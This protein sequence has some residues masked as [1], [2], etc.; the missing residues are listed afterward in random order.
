MPDKLSLKAELR[1]QIDQGREELIDLTRDLLRFDTENPP[2]NSRPITEYIARYL[3]DAGIPTGIHV[4]PGDHCNL[5]AEIEA[6][7]PGK[8]LLFCGHTDV[9]PAGD[10]ARWDFPPTAGDVVDGYLRGRGASDMK[11]G[12]AGFLFAATLLNRAKDRLAG[13]IGLVVVDDEETGGEHGA[14]WILGQGLVRGDGCIIAEPTGPLN[15]TIGQKGCCWFEV[16]FFGTPAHGSLAPL[17]GENAILK[18]CAA[19]QELQKLFRMPVRVPADLAETVAVSK[20]RL[21]EEGRGDVAAV[22]DHVSVNVGIIHGGTKTNIVP[23]RCVFEV[24][25]RVPFGLS[26]HDVMAEARRLLD[27]LGHRYEIRPI[28]FQCAANSTSPKDPVVAAVLRAVKEVRGGNPFGVLQ[29][30]TSDARWF[31]DHGIPVLQYGPAELGTIHAWNERVKVEDVVACA[32]V[33]AAAAVEYL[34]G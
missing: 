30:A 21:A 11:A 4:A 33:Y 10:P 3:G 26:H 34:L 25:T 1:R 6:P 22:L 24:D 28:K 13:S 16:T 5:L 17:A 19:A 15:P 27:E 31:R 23:D 7:R 8:R 2:G 18:A 32:Q 9:V 14:Q 12:V 29:W 20:A